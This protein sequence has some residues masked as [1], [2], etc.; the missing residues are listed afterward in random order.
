MTAH[1][2]STLDMS[3]KNKDVN[4][5]SQDEVLKP[6]YENLKPFI[7]FIERG[8]CSTCIQAKVTLEHANVPHICYSVENNQRVVRSK[9]ELLAVE[10]PALFSI[11]AGKMDTYGLGYKNTADVELNAEMF[12]RAIEHNDP[13][14]TKNAPRPFMYDPNKDQ[15]IYGTMRIELHMDVQY[16]KNAQ[17]NLNLK[18][19]LNNPIR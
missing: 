2:D 16:I 10:A 4:F 8:G 19:Q 7:V 3:L 5:T 18:K 11:P 17:M 15:Y 12:I 14:T 1:N 6:E 13:H 9:K